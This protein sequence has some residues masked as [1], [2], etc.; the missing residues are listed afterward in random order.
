MDIDRK[1]SR[2]GKKPAVSD[3]RSGASRAVLALG[4]V[5]AV[6]V[7]SIAIM[8]RPGPEEPEAV[9]APRRESPTAAR[10]ASGFVA[11]LREGAGSDASRG[12]GARLPAPAALE[13]E[14]TPDRV[15]AA[16]TPAVEEEEEEEVIDN[17]PGQELP[18]GIDAAE[19]IQKLR[20]MGE[21]EGIAAFPPPGTD[22]PKAGVVVPDDYDVPEGYERYYQYTDDGKPLDPI[23]LFS[24]EYDFFDDQG[25]PVPIPENRV[26][27]PDQAPGDLPVEI[28]DP[29]SPRE[30]RGLIGQDR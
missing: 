10:R 14:A 2:I 25:N 16:E 15:A 12:G 9:A 26:V 24:P 5:A 19:Y 3:G 20:D 30:P 27:P 8:Y 11:R 6:L 13:R 4:A 18:R 22:P 28:L 23:L 1:N 29:E 21:T 17:V 7:A